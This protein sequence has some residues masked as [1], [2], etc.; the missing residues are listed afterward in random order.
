[1]RRLQ[2]GQAEPQTEVEGPP[3]IWKAA[4]AGDTAEISRLLKM[5]VDVDEAWTEGASPLFVASQRG[6]VAAVQQLLRNSPESLDKACTWD[7][8]T[9]LRT[10][11]FNG[12]D[13]VV[14][15]LMKEYADRSDRHLSSARDGIDVVGIP[16][17]VG[18]TPHHSKSNPPV[19]QSH[20]LVETVPLKILV[21]GDAKVGKSSL[22]SQFRNG[23][24]AAQYVP[25]IGVDFELKSFRL[26]GY[27]IKV[28]CWDT[29]GDERFRSIVQQYLTRG[30]HGVI[31]VYDITDAK[32]F[33]STEMWLAKVVQY[34]STEASTPM[35]LVGNKIDLALQK[36]VDSSVAMVLADKFGASFIETSAK[37]GVATE[38][39]FMQLTTSII[40]SWRGYHGSVK[41]VPASKR[42]EHKEKVCVVAGV[43]AKSVPNPC[44]N[45][46]RQE[47]QEDDAN[48]SDDELF[49]DV[50]E[51]PVLRASEDG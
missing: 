35:L 46:D 9:A 45:P 39:A 42:G 41:S 13:T 15:L 11:S 23:S 31:V 30:V 25:T 2:Q 20:E 18:Y 43:E 28:Q 37:E 8:R 21:V 38:A 27:K 12:H 10:A 19:V 48:S 6:H 16:T 40:R 49:Y 1:M 14:E 5:G 44:P 32:T 47:T 4:E 17:W 33:E 22:W 3:A 51:Q 34:C 50:A 29:A 7:G 24:F 36:V 26:G